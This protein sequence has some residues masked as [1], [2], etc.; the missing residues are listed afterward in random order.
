MPLFSHPKS[1]LLLV[2][3]GTPVFAGGDPATVGSWSEPF[4]LPLIAIHAAALPTGDVLLFSAEHGVPGI[5]G[6]LLDPQTLLL[7]EVAPPRPW[8]PDCAGHSF[9]PDGRLLV[10]GGTLA[11][12]PLTGAAE[13]FAFNPYTN[14]WEELPGMGAGR[15]YPT[16]VTLPGGQVE[17]FAGLSD[18]PNV[19]NEDIERF[20]PLAPGEWSLVGEKVL[21]YYPLM[22]VLTDGRI[23]MAGP[24]PLAETYDP[25]TNTWT[26]VDSMGFPGRYEAP[27]VLLPGLHRVMV[28][29]GFTGSGQ[30]TSSC[31]IIDLSAPE[32][33]WA[34]AP[35]MAQA[36]MEHDA[37]LLPTG[38]VLVVGGTS[39]N[40]A[41][42]P[43]LVPEVF[44]P[45]NSAWESLAPHAVPRMYHSTTILLPD[46][47]VLA[48]GADSQASGEIF[49]PPYL[50]RGPRPQVTQAPAAIEY[51]ESFSLGFTTATE[52]NEVVLVRYSSVTHSNNMGQRW[53]RLAQLGGGSG[54]YD[55]PA[56]LNAAQTPP[57]FYMLFV[58]NGDGVPSLALTVRVDGPLPDC[59]ANGVADDLDLAS[60]ES[61]DF[62]ANLLP[63][64]C[65]SLSAD[66]AVLSVGAGGTQTLSLDA[67][68]GFSGELYWTLGSVSGTTPGI[69]VGPLLIPLNY[70][71]YT[72]FTLLQ[73]NGAPLVDSS[74][75]LDVSG[76]GTMLFMA[77]PGVL[78]ASAVGLS[79]NHA[80]VV[81]GDG[82]AMVFASNAMPLFL[83]A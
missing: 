57:G 41:P 4:D 43:V 78:P 18:V 50:F 81:F 73:P 16:T 13:T 74:G 30:P 36:R 6:W 38:Q 22:H 72:T 65:E 17:V 29:G 2:V 58:V 42:S 68:S 51:G 82:L 28:I 54:T 12:S 44:D 70:D 80:F 21:P 79:L 75:S 9:L 27:S 8:N 55:I 66:I 32:P 37:V 83:D 7:A 26:P 56:P 20:D 76:E 63:D 46:G 3:L 19:D 62:N 33:S 25:L 47:R 45:D 34:S 77:G 24:E 67:G 59:N 69:P 31:E 40:P 49:S 14:S 23:F 64:D 48:A 35:H 5:H 61:F 53:V 39:T 1:A 60:G 10:A 71:F 11:F 52:A 15:W